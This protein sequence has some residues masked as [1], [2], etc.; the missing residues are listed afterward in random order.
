M[1]CRIKKN[2]GGGRGSK[3]IFWGVTRKF[4]KRIKICL[5]SFVLGFYESDKHFRE[6]KPL[7]P[8]DMAMLPY[9]TS[10]RKS[11]PRKVSVCFPISNTRPI[12][13]QWAKFI[14]CTPSPGAVGGKAIHKYIVLRFF[15]VDHESS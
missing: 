13:K 6:F 4:K 8:L 10:G 11:P 12:C 15:A 2:S 7:N 3:T 14:D 5:F 9:N 1:Q